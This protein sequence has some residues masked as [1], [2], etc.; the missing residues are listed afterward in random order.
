[1]ARFEGL[2]DLIHDTVDLVTDLVEE[3]HEGSVAKTMRLL[4]VVEPMG[5][6]ARGVDAVRR[7]LT[8]GVY[9]AVRGTNRVVQ[10]ATNVG[11][12]AV[13]RGLGA[14]PGTP[15]LLP[16]APHGEP[17]AVPWADTAQAA[18]NAAFGD[19]LEA[20]GN[21]LAI[22]MELWHD[23]RPLPVERQTLVRA[24]PEATG[25]LCVFVHGLGCTE[26]EWCLGAE[27]V[28]GDP[29]TCYATLL[30]RD[31]GY[32]PAHI[33]YN[34]GLH[35]SDNGRRLAGLLE[36]LVAAHPTPVRE[37]VLVGHSMGG[38]VS[39][40]AVHYGDEAGHAWMNALTHVICIGSPHHGAPLEKASNALA[41]MLA[42]FDT[43]GTQVPAKLLR[44]R[45]AGIK[46]LRH[47]NVVEEDW[48]GVDPDG[49]DDRRTRAR[50]VAGVSY[51]AISGCV[52][53][54]PDHPLGRLLGDVLVR[55]PSAHGHHEDSA[56]HIPFEGSHVL[57]GVDHLTLIN[58]PDVYE[59]I[60]TALGGARRD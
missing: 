20:R 44:A 6:A 2:R 40:S 31:L 36:A 16:G 46:D 54:D 45:S 11:L 33:R 26:R 49:H 10:A 59:V 56:R 9:G 47:G 14:G 34:T 57:E 8:A 1:M 22:P 41:T 42:W 38:L 51:Y 25:R 39:R 7:P 32:T 18:L 12:G 5:T 58:H 37:L 52:T 19:F 3:T 53:S 55:V 21:G 4:E 17:S 30:Q 15:R 60:R 50:L 23:G 27:R 48:R 29:H 13:T 28:W 35:I 43:A 24:W